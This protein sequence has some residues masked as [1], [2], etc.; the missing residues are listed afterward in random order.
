M[1]YNT[2]QKSSENLNSYSPDHDWTVTTESTELRVFKNSRQFGTALQQHTLEILSQLKQNTHTHNII[3]CTVSLHIHTT[4]LHMP[5]AVHWCCKDTRSCPDILSCWLLQQYTLRR[6]S[7]SL[8]SAPVSVEWGSATHRMKAQ[9]RPHHRHVMTFIGCRCDNAF[10]TSWTRW[11]SSA[12]SHGAVVPS[13]HVH[14]CV[15]YNWSSTSP[16]CHPS[17]SDNSTQSIGAIWI[18]QLRRF[19]PFDLELVATDCSRHE[20]YIH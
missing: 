8:A 1:A 18:T 5:Y 3:C 11:C 7:S 10:S 16:F 19:R 14:S 15:I 2:A 12:L 13:R 6:V 4:H 9:V 20:P 17:Q